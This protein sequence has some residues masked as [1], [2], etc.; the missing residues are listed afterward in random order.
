MDG[1]KIVVFTLDKKGYK[2]LE[3]LKNNKDKG[4][5]EISKQ[6]KIAPKN[7][8]RRLKMYVDCGWVTKETKP[9]SP[10]GRKRI[11]SLSKQGLK[12]IRSLN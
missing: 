12:T 10:R 7:M 6:N 9:V 11:Y 5:L 8:L 2:I 3:T 1:M 4:L